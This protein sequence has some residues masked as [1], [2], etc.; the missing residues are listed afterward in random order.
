MK[1]IILARVSTDEQEEAGNSLPAQIE[2]LKKYCQIKNIEILE[3]F[4]FSESAYKTKRDEFDRILN[5]VKSSKEKTIVCFDKVD[6]FSR[7][8]FDKR[9]S[10]LYDLSMQ[11]KIELHFV[12]DGLIINSNISAGQKFQFG[13]QLGLSK[14]Y[15][16][17]ISDNVK[18]AYEN[19][20]KS[21]EW[22]GKAP[23]G[24]VN[25]L[26]ENKGI[27]PD[28]EKY[29]FVVKIFELYATGNCSLLTLEKEI[30]KMGLTGTRGGKAISRGMLYHVLNNPFYYGVMRIK[31]NLYE[32]KY[33]PIISEEIFNKCQAVML[34][35]NKKPWQPTA[36]PYI[37][38][39]L[40][41][42]AE[43]GCA[44]TPET[45]K[46]HIYYHCTNYKKIHKNVIYIR[47]EDLLGPI[48]EVFKKIQFSEKEIEK[49]LNDLKILSKNENKFNERSINVLRK[50]YD[51][52]RT[53]IS[54]SFDL[55]ADGN[56][57]KEMF[58]EKLKEYK[59]RQSE[60]ETEMSMHTEADESFYLTANTV[61]NLAKRAGEIFESSKVDEKR[62]L[63]N[64]L[65]QNLE[66]KE[67][68]LVFMAREPFNTMLKFNERPIGQGRQESNPQPSVLKTA[69]LPVELRP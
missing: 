54:A 41:K 38:R 16:D 42:C 60:I 4:K 67:K 31:N 57:T 10:A 45:K 12:S 26:N 65:L 49:I 13:M 1:A 24:Y 29:H 3:V 33:Q 23:I 55:L 34:G 44:I 18:R 40:I 32:H 46:G 48:Y 43:C 53:R 14:Y 9:V 50:E 5:L 63:L 28:P 19:K 64:L 47:E 30:K 51:Q 35:H 22:I 61:L 27:V 17:A 52:V 39:G 68:K 37:L 36:K 58:D 20:I 7:N 69:A 62:Q 8:V 11:D 25:M 6:R 15:S 2:R 56:I 59:K 66:L 21:G